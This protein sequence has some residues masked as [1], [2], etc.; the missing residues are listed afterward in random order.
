MDLVLGAIC[1]SLCVAQ[2]VV[3]LAGHEVLVSH[4]YIIISRGFVI[5]DDVADQPPE[6]SLRRS[7]V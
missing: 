2:Y 1:G 7:L 3:M 4:K 6:M 5:D